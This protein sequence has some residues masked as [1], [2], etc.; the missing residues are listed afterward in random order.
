MALQIAIAS[1]VVIA[2][3]A[4]TATITVAV[5][6]TAFAIA[7]AIPIAIAATKGYVDILRFIM[8]FSDIRKKTGIVEEDI[9]KRLQDP[10]EQSGCCQTGIRVEAPSFQRAQT[11]RTVKV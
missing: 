11:M 3:V 4:E 6:M 9:A 7:I 10:C 8:D 1:A 5:L 2:I